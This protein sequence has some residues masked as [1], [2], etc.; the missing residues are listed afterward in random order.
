MFHHEARIGY[1]QID[2]DSVQTGIL[3]YLVHKGLQKI[4]IE[5]KQV[6]TDIG[7]DFVPLEPIDIIT[8]SENQLLQMVKG[9]QEEWARQA[10]EAAEKQDVK[11]KGKRRLTKGGLRVRFA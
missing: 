8:K 2:G 7:D 11:K 5:A 1:S 3:F 9:L 10:R 6:K 4:E